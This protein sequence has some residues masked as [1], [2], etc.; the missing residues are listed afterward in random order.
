MISSQSRPVSCDCLSVFNRCSSVSD[1]FFFPFVFLYI[2]H[3]IMR[4]RSAERCCHGNR[5]IARM[6][7]RATDMVAHCTVQSISWPGTTAGDYF[8]ISSTW[9]RRISETVVW[10]SRSLLYRKPV[11]SLPS[12]VL[13]LS[14]NFAQAVKN[15]HLAKQHNS[16]LDS[17]PLK[18]LL[19]KWPFS[20]IV[21]VFLCFQC[22]IFRLSSNIVAK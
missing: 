13:L 11:C 9:K 3:T 18:S 19:S 16:E 14:F 5:K 22:V 12:D 20:Q 2:F 8:K 4:Q 17:S 6:T 15:V 7:M 10:A 1:I 21:S